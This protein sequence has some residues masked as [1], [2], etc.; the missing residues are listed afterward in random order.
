VIGFQVGVK[1]K[2]I[3]VLA[4]E[5]KSTLKLQDARTV[6]KIAKIDEHICLAFAGLTAGRNF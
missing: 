4:V 6:R 2:D 5:K 1:G 3:L